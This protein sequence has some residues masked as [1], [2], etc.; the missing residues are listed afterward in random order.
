[1]RETGTTTANSTQDSADEDAADAS[2]GASASVPIPEKQIVSRKW[3]DACVEAR[4][5][6]VDVCVRFRHDLL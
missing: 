3:V 6:V 2:D 1:M 4:E 5:Q